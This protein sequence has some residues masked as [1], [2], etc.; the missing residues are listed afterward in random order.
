M[1]QDIE[2]TV[3]E[4]GTDV[5]RPKDRELTRQQERYA[6]PPVDIY[7]KQDALTV[8]AD[9]PG[10]AAA[11]LSVHVEQGVLTIEGKVDAGASGD[12]LLQE[13][14]LTSFYRQFRIAETIDTEKI[15]AALHHGVLHLT[16]PKVE[17]AKP[18]QIPVVAS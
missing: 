13:F 5:A 8:L 6:S 3:Q 18:R 9:L 16:L 2:K 1:A 10:V 14:D 17:K 12:L 11:G 15:S 7:E 4:P